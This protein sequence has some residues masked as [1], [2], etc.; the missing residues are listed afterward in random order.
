MDGEDVDEIESQIEPKRMTHKE[1]SL[2]D[3]LTR[4]TEQLKIAQEKH[5]EAMQKVQELKR[6]NERHER[7]IDCLQGIIQQRTLQ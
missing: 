1:R 6:A 2:R 5:E 7:T 4:T 3:E